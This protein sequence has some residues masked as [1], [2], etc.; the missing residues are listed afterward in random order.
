MDRSELLHQLT[1]A[2]WNVF[3]GAWRLAGQ[4]NAVRR[5]RPFMRTRA[6]ALLKYLEREQMLAVREALQL[7]S[8]FKVLLEI[9]P[10]K[11]G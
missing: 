9:P 7:R 1:D 3:Q 2:E 8:Q 5:F 4:R 6:A 11:N 10:R